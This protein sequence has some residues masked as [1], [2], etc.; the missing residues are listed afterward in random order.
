MPFESRNSNRRLSS[1]FT[2]ILAQTRNP[3]RAWA[4]YNRADKLHVGRVPVVRIAVVVGIR[5]VR[6]A[7]DGAQPEVAACTENNLT[8]NPKR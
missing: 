1:P 6:R 8:H 2:L 5:K 7:R 4:E 3:V